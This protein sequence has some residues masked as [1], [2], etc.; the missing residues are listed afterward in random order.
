LNLLGLS[1]L[2]C[3][4][5]KRAADL[6]GGALAGDDPHIQWILN[7][8]EPFRFEVFKKLAELSQSNAILS[9]YCSEKGL[10]FLG[11]GTSRDVFAL[12][13]QRV[14]KIASGT[15]GLA[16]NEVEVEVFTNPKTR[17][18]IAKIYDMDSGYRWIVSERAEPLHFE[19]ALTEAAGVDFYALTSYFRLYRDMRQ[20]YMAMEARLKGQYPHPRTRMHREMDQ[21]ELMESIENAH[22][23]MKSFEQE[24]W[25]GRVPEFVKAV[26]SLFD[27]SDLLSGDVG[28]ADSWGKTPD[29]RLI[30][31]DYGASEQVFWDH[32][33]A[34]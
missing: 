13:N 2:Y 1:S 28:R 34:A 16:Q 4:L 6:P 10:T 20:A 27:F 3:R 31:I 9:R 26:I 17:P 14:L 33:I 7:S 5:C 29:G 12:D 22:G 19:G 23:R 15:K 24:Y 8:P 30:L 25:D 32:Y 11:E 18:I 21:Q